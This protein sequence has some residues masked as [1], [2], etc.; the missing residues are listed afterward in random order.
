MIF[1]DV[2]AEYSPDL[3]L[4]V[5]SVDGTNYFYVGTVGDMAD[6]ID[7]YNR[8]LYGH[9]LHLKKKSEKR[10]QIHLANAP[11]PETYCRSQM[12]KVAPDLTVDGYN[13]E[14]RWWFRWAAIKYAT[15]E[16]RE[17]LLARFTELPF[18]EVIEHGMADSLADP[19]CVRIVIEGGETGKWWST[20][21]AKKLPDIS[22]YIEDEDEEGDEGET[23]RALDDLKEGN[24]APY[25]KREESL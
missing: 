7:K 10:V 25:K 18:R 14:L 3:K 23:L 16:K 6:H 17:S 12:K 13:A 22:F 15:L 20:D 8:C 9:M 21:E 24:R 2:L 4:K 5:G 1:V 19:D 11:T